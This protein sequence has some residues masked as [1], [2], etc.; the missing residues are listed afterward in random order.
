MTLAP[1]ERQIGSRR[2]RMRKSIEHYS[3]NDF[4]VFAIH[5][6]EKQ[7]EHVSDIQ[8]VRGG[9]RGKNGEPHSY[10]IIICLIT[11]EFE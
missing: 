1:E 2:E 6:F 9:G 10:G 3:L 8:R 7:N 5:S 11:F 4:D